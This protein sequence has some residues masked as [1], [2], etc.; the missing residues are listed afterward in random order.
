M[1]ISLIDTKTLRNFS[2]KEIEREM[3]KSILFSE[4]ILTNSLYEKNFNK[5]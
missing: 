5:I 2:Y 4:K 3:L 1:F